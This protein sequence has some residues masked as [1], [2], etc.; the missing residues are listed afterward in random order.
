MATENRGRPSTC[1]FSMLPEECI[2]HLLSFTS[3]CDICRSSLVSKSFFAA[4][5]S[6]LLW[7]SFL[8]PDIAEILSR[9][10]HP[11]ELDSS[12][13][14]LYF[15]LCQPFLVDEGK[16]SFQLDRPTGKQTYMLSPET[17]S[18]VG[19][20]HPQFWKWI[21]LPDSRFRKQA[22]LVSVCWLEITSRIDS[23]LLSQK[24]MYTAYMIYKLNPDS[25]GLD[26]Q[27]ASIKLGAHSQ[28]QRVSLIPD[29]EE[30]E[31][32]KQ[33]Q[34]RED[35]WLEVVLGEIYNDQGDEGDI[36][37]KF[38]D[39]EDIRDIKEFH[40]KKGL[41]FAGFEMRPTKRKMDAELLR[42][43]A[44]EN[45]GRPSTCGFSMLPEKC[46]SYLLS[47]TSPCDICRLSL[48][49]KSFL[50]AAQT[51]L[52]WES[53]LPPD[54]AE[55]LSRAVHPVDYSSKKEL[56]FSLCQPLL[57]DDGK[58]V[59]LPIG[60]VNRK[61]YVHAISG[62]HTYTL[63]R[64]SSTLEMEFSSPLQVNATH[65]QEQRVSL[66]PDDEEE[67]EKQI[68]LR[69]DGWL[70]MVLGEIY[71]DQGDEGDIE[72]KFL[73]IEELHWKKGLVFAGFEMRPTKRKMDVELLR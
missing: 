49:S 65:S 12:G 55:I 46:I 38:R 18:I 25:Y 50:A 58:L 48:V 19:K 8:P 24:T 16:L 62:N 67:V 52:L 15:R 23:R 45:R 44:T 2:S 41:V 31:V 68:Q 64:S 54:V 9:A 37:I 71:N 17:M 26:S 51:D 21:S 14:E 60:K 66:I 30:E 70:E 43:M 22:V 39:I 13:K 3:P 61:E 5:Q 28:E 63:D 4:A 7:E 27:K 73:D 35:G 32:E 40:W 42:A 57:V 53:F 59:E 47:F 56:Y 34:L 11:V 69:E 29:D 6:D 20:N 1:G 33:I 36:E 72:I 10:T